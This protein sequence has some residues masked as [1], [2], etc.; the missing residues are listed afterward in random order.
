[1]SEPANPYAENHRALSGFF[2]SLTA[3]WMT[4]GAIGFAE[5]QPSITQPISILYI[6]IIT[7]LTLLFGWV[8]WGCA[9]RYKAARIAAELIA[10]ILVLR[11][12]VV[13]ALL[14]F[15]VIYPS[16]QWEPVHD[17]TRTHPPA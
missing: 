4:L 8:A 16:A 1:M 3:L 5:S 13:G 12:P 2:V 6:I 9:Q 10:S 17:D 7:S 14:A 15:L 11:F